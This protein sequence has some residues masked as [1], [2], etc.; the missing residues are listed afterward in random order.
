MQLHTIDNKK[1][2][3][4]GISELSNHEGE[5]IELLNIEELRSLKFQHPELILIDIFGEEI[6]AK[7][8]SEDERL[9]Y[10]A[11]GFLYGYFMENQYP[12]E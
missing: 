7:D 12:L 1:M 6:S 5:T 3:E 8:T 4:L 9:G 2:A 10:S 11:Y